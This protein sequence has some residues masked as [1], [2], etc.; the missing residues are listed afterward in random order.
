MRAPRPFAL[1]ALL[2]LALVAA[3]GCRIRFSSLFPLQGIKGSGNVI[4]ETRQ[5]EP[6]HAIEVHAAL[7]VRF[8]PGEQTTLAIRGD[9]NILPL[10]IT[11]VRGGV[12]VA[13]LTPN[14]NIQ[15]SD[16]IEIT[17]TS[18]AVSSLSAHGASRIEA[19][20]TAQPETAIEAHG[21]SKIAVT[22]IDSE[23]LSLVASGAS[24]IRLEGKATSAD[25]EASGASNV[26]AD[27]LSVST[28]RVDL[29]GASRATLN[30]A[31][32]VEGNA[33]G[34]SAIVLTGKPGQVQ[35]RTSGASRVSYAETK[36]TDA[37]QE[38]A[39]APIR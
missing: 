1:A 33:S 25:L 20:L 26:N 3:P 14:K 27:A 38:S 31:T 32:A 5:V 10:V 8:M 22:G 9:D 17:V 35:V 19:T 39:P 18:P 29:S 23:S 37:D 36:P 15:T 4:E 16:P 28:A 7:S 13:E 2:G 30:A 12:L 21:A 34:A 6:F 24:R 11:T